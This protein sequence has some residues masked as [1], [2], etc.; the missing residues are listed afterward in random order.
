MIEYFFK[1]FSL[2]VTF[3]ILFVGPIV[4]LFLSL[5]SFIV[6]YVLI[7]WRNDYVISFQGLFLPFLVVILTISNIL[8]T[9]LFIGFLSSRYVIKPLKRLNSN[10]SKLRESDY[11]IEIK[12]TG[13]REFDTVVNEL[14][15]LSHK[16]KT[17]AELR[18]NLISDTS[19]ELKTPITA[20][21]L[22]LQGI[23]DGVMEIDKNTVSGL[24]YQVE[25]LNDLIQN[26]E[27]YSIIRANTI[28][29]RKDKIDV[30]ILLDR[31]VKSLNEKLTLA[32]ITVSTIIPEKFNLYADPVL[33]DRLFSNLINNSIKYSKGSEIRIYFD[34]G[35]LIF[36]DN[37]VGVEL[38]KIPY[39]FERFYRIENSR[40]RNEGGLGLGLSIVR[41][42][43]EAH[44]WKIQVDEKSKGLKFVIILSSK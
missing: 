34:S 20:L 19:H 38:S 21:I 24:L 2:R 13:V 40:N 7:Q 31:L 5:L 17:E 32:E 33:I 30:N 27:E 3:L 4:F 18:K 12:K 16:L 29:I 44:G 28:R 25:R 36:C 11:S 43:V 10:I 14:N 22:Q 6:V 23:K 41:E 9:T 42:I 8:L 39:I 1:R 26:L 15:K 35:N 37:G